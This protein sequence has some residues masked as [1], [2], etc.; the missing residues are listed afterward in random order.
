MPAFT[1]NSVGDIVADFIGADKSLS[2]D[3]HKIRA[4]DNYVLF[5]AENLFSLLYCQVTGD[6][7][8]IRSWTELQRELYEKERGSRKPNCYLVFVIPREI[9]GRNDL[10]SELVKAEQNEYF[11]R[12][13]FIEVPERYSRSTIEKSLTD[14]L[15]LWISDKETVLRE[16][17]PL[18]EDVIADSGLRRVLQES[19]AARAVQRM[20]SEERFSWLFQDTS[21]NEVS[22]S[23]RKDSTVADVPLEQAVR[24]TELELSDFRC[25]SHVSIDLDADLSII[26]GNNG[27]GKTTIIDGLEFSLFRKIRR[28]DY[29]PDLAVAH[30]GKYIP[31]LNAKG[32]GTKKAVLKLSGCRGS[33]PFS[34]TTRIGGSSCTTD[35]NEKRVG[36]K[37]VLKLLVEDSKLV[38]KKEFQDILLHTHFLGQHSI[39]H[40]IYGINTSDSDMIRRNRY[41]LISQVFGFG[42]IVKVRDRLSRLISEISRTKIKALATTMSADKK[43][44][45]SL[46]HKFG[47]KRRAEINDRGLAINRARAEAAFRVLFERLQDELPNVAGNIEPGQ[48]H[49]PEYYELACQAALSAVRE[50]IAQAERKQSHLVKIDKL[51]T[52][53]SSILSNSGWPVMAARTREFVAFVRNSLEDVTRLLEDKRYERLGLEKRIGELEDSL[54]AISNL[55]K[56][57]GRLSELKSRRTTLVDRLSMAHDEW[58]ILSEKKESLEERLAD[59][60]TKAATIRRDL[61]EQEKKLAECQ[62]AKVHLAEVPPLRRVIESNEKEIAALDDA[63]AQHRL[64]VAQLGG[65]EPADTRLAKDDRRLKE[66]ICYLDTNGKYTCPFCG[67]GYVERVDLE[68]AVQIQLD[69]GSHSQELAEFIMTIISKKRHLLLAEIQTSVS[70]MIARRSDLT[71][72]NDRLRNKLSDIET[73]LTKT[74]GTKIGTDEQVASAISEVRNRVAALR[75]ELKTYDET[76]VEDELEITRKLIRD[77]GYSSLIEERDQVSLEILRLTQGASRLLPK[78]GD[79]DLSD[80]EAVKRKLTEEFEANGESL[81]SLNGQVSDAE[82]LDSRGDE[83]EADLTEMQSLIERYALE[84]RELPMRAPGDSDEEFHSKQLYQSVVQQLEDLAFVFGAIGVDIEMSAIEKRIEVTR[85]EIRR[86]STCRGHLKEMQ[87]KIAEVSRAGLEKSLEQYSPLIN[88]IYKKFSRHEY[89]DEVAL[90]P[91]STPQGRKRDL[92][93]LLK[94]Y[95]GEKEGTPSSYLSEAQLNIL[96]LSIFLTR[97]IYQNVSVLQTVLIDDPVQQMD[98]MN[99]LAFIDIILGLSRAGKQIIITTCNRD[100]FDLFCSKARQTLASSNRTFRAI[101]LGSESEKVR[102]LCS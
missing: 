26:Y 93:I 95:S 14:R 12:K 64:R 29:D 94:N 57:Y 63:I 44:L 6:V 78:S 56:D 54:I 37:Q 99:A 92:F 90:K 13:I 102:Y 70:E 50:G 88:E 72:D 69:S 87:T 85:E 33:Q 51:Y 19:T 15:P 27:C 10:Y 82:A 62:R 25:F 68:E 75:D 43:H 66:V 73:L 21:A 41:D 7:D 24:L 20:D 30:K 83:I 86:W 4:R 38:E 35:L 60:G 100:L 47:P 18:V 74:I 101:E 32:R 79:Y 91:L 11:F 55:I 8:V 61:A 48:D 76:P 67:T 59:F 31:L 36:P 53:I 42:R 46:Q 96:A 9:V 22:E 81:R 45:R 71:L 1:P 80:M 39:R 23:D 28:L 40:F 77:L 34:I 49:S 17:I 84:N 58:L 3:L 5:K 2:Y 65:K 98:D 97:V 89:F 52:K 16:H